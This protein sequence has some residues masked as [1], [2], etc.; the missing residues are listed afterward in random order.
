MKPFRHYHITT[1]N[2]TQININVD[3]PI[4]YYLPIYHIQYCIGEMSLTFHFYLML[5]NFNGVPIYWG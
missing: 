1:I 3:G 5:F 4:H 2:I